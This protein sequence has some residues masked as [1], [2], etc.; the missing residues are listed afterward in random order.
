MINEK[1]SIYA[2]ICQISQ[3]VV[4]GIFYI[5]EIWGFT[6]LTKISCIRIDLMQTIT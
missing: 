1:L 5:Y 4:L 3:A 2:K 6:I